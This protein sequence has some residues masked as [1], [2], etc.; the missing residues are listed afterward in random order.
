MITTPLLVRL[1]NLH[2]L[3][4]HL[5]LELVIQLLLLLLK[6]LRLLLLIQGGLLGIC[7]LHFLLQSLLLLLLLLVRLRRFLLPL[8]TKAAPLLLRAPMILLLVLTASNRGK[9]VAGAGRIGVHFRRTD[10]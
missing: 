2:L 6:P 1:L 3:H 8:K 7:L 10:F 9:G 4:L 5:L